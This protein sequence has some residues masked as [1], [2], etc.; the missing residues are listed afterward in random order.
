M[1]VRILI[2]ILISI[3]II[4]IV[5]IYLCTWGIKE[6]EKRVASWPIVNS[7]IIKVGMR[8]EFRGG[9]S[10]TRPAAQKFDIC[11]SGK[12]DY[13][14]VLEQKKFVGNQFI[15]HCFEPWMKNRMKRFEENF[16]NGKQIKI[17]YN[18]FNPKE[19]LLDL[20]ENE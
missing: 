19:S 8:E 15:D 7:Q 12:I 10:S 4:S 3:F 2:G 17:H 9:V 11:F 20:G 5:F 13:E 1:K 16:Q 6:H 14:Y 18:P